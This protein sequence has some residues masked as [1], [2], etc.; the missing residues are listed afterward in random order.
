MCPVMGAYRIA[1]TVRI[2]PECMQ[3]PTPGAQYGQVNRETHSTLREELSKG[4]GTMDKYY[5]NAEYNAAFDRCIDVMAKIVLKYGD[6]ILKNKTL[7]DL[8]E[9]QKAV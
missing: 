3:W 8:L 6:Q 5:D 9:E 1:I 4:Y 2:P 7:G